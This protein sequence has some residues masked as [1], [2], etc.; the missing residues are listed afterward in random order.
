ME[1]FAVDVCNECLSLEELLQRLEDLGRAM[2][3]YADSLLDAGSGEAQP[4]VPAREEMQG[5]K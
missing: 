2:R 3:S 1:D 4:A 5:A